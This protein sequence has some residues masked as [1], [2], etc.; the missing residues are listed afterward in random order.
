MKKMFLSLIILGSLAL[1]QGCANVE[2]ETE[3]ET[4]A[5]EFEAQELEV[6]SRPNQIGNLSF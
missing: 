5:E 1:F 2:L 6:T 3:N 4:R